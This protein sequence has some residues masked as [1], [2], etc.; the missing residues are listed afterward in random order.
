MFITLRDGSGYLQC[1]LT[2][3]LCQTYNALILATE[4][5]VCLWGTLAAVPEGHRVRLRYVTYLNHS[6]CNFRGS[7]EEIT[8]IKISNIV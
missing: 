6:V 8:K 2:D 7:N 4:S 5:S 1:V 3:R